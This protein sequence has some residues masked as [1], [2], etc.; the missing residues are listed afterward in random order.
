[1]AR[2]MDKNRAIVY[3]SGI[4]AW[5]VVTLVRTVYADGKPDPLFKMDLNIPKK[6]E[7]SDG[8]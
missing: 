3:I 4:F 7:G 6:S 5:G 8:E 2:E 1:M